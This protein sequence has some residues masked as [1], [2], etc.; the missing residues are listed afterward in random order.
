MTEKE[1]CD[2]LFEYLRNIL[3]NNECELPDIEKL[4]E[5]YQK[6]GQELQVLHKTVAEMEQYSADLSI[7]NLSGKFPSRDNFL[8]SN[9]K[10][11][12]ANLIHLTCQTKQVAS[13]DYSQNVSYLGEL[14]EAFDMMAE[15]LKEREAQLNERVVREQKRAEMFE[16]YNELIMVMM[17]KRNEWMIVIDQER[18][19]VVYCSRGRSKM[20]ETQNAGEFSQVDLSFDIELLKMKDCDNEPV[21]ELDAPSGEFYRVTS[22]ASVWNGRDSYIHVIENITEEKLKTKNLT[23]IAYCDPGTGIHNR[24]YFEEHVKHLMKEKENITLCY[25]DLDGLKYVNDHY[26]HNQGDNYIRNFV[27]QIQKSFRS[28]DVFTR[29][30]GD[31]FCLVLP[32]CKKDIVME[33]ISKTQVQFVEN[34]KEP[35]PVSFSYGVVEV[36]GDK[37]QPSLEEILSQADKEMYECK[38]RNR[39][40]Y[41]RDYFRNY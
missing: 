26:G 2:M 22:F 30:G 12:H 40:L 14:S 37:E 24:R 36:D 9:L 5:P 29:L 8:C 23:N 33:K 11:L 28:D 19:D 39:T 18:E 41:P 31:E 35:Y 32:G 27:D 17:Q 6:L 3:Y 1:N 16:K 21:W 20:P 10:S 25:M 7:G 38:R 34:N 4:D 13:G 15:K